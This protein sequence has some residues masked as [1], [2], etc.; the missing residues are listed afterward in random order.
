MPAPNRPPQES[1]PVSYVRSIKVMDANGVD[2]TLFEFHERRFLRKV[3]RLKLETGEMVE[4]IGGQLVVVGTGE[5]LTR[6]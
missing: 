6:L 3:R 4:E 5:T 2:L 1:G